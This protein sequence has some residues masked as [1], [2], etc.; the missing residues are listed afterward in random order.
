MLNNLDYFRQLWTIANKFEQFHTCLGKIRKVWKSPDQFGQLWVDF[1]HFWP[2]QFEQLLISLEL[3]MHL[4]FMQLSLTSKLLAMKYEKENLTDLC[5]ELV[6]K[7]LN[8]LATILHVYACVLT[9]MK[10][11][12]IIFQK[13]KGNTVRTPS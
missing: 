5:L 8:H 6:F 12:N 13:E 10:K 1:D 3:A 4:H 11:K 2:I 7:E 9:F